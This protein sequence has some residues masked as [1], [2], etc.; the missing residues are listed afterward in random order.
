VG[1]EQAIVQTR[2]VAPMLTITKSKRMI[3]FV[4][5]KKVKAKFYTKQQK[6][7]LLEKEKNKTQKN[8]S[9]NCKESKKKNPTIQRFYRIWRVPV[10]LNLEEKREI[11]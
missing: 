5:R 2:C 1:Y 7:N 6:Y 3:R 10:L 11:A 8:K 9:I 4:K